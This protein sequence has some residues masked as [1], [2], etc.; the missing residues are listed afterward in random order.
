MEWLGQGQ[1]FVPEAGLELRSDTSSGLSVAQ[2]QSLCLFIY[3]LIPPHPSGDVPDS[4]R[5]FLAPHS[6]LPSGLGKIP[7]VVFEWHFY[8]GFPSLTWSVRENSP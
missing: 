4:R 1:T 5:P 3:L 7:S 2:C 8:L 6:L